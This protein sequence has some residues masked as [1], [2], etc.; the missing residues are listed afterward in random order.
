MNPRKR[1]AFVGIGNMGTPM[2]ANL[3]KAGHD[4][5]LYDLN[6][7]RAREHA[8]AIGCDAA[9]DLRGLADGREIV[10]TMLPDDRSVR[11]LMLEADGQGLAAHLSRNTILIDMSSSSP[12]ATRDLCGRLAERGLRM[13]DAP[14]SGLV[15]RA[16]D[17]TLTIMVGC[18]DESTRIEA[19]SVLCAMGN[20]IL[21]VGG[22]GCGHAMKALNNVVA[23]TCFAVTAE[24][25]IAGSRFG[26]DP[27]TMIDVIDSASGRNFHTATSFPNE[28]LS[29]RLASGFTA[30]LLAK[31][32]GIAAELASSLGLETPIIE[33]SASRWRDA[34]QALAQG[35]DNTAA[36]ALWADQNHVGLTRA[37]GNGAD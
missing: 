16:R 17:A 4:V 37:A 21:A 12:A 26:L 1:I 10:I 27:G 11:A 6:V 32:V 9:D 19:E 5:R 3:V 7:A 23:A 31:D 24:A 34:A 28:V 18:D 36:A 33:L 25:L 2:S 22:T 20:R 30:A 15:P 29:G 35:A 13:V 8:R 14:V